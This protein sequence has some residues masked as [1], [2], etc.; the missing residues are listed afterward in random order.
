[1]KER[2]QKKQNQV[3]KSADDDGKNK[4]IINKTHVITC[5]TVDESMHNTIIRNWIKKKIKMMSSQ[6]AANKENYCYRGETERKN[7][8]F[9]A[10]RI[11]S[12]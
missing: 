2:T 4:V 11:E 8:D 10:I 3:E 9:F 6:N 12:W 1:M 5:H 7:T